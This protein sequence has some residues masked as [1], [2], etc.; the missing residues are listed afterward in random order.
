MFKL[1]VSSIGLTAVLLAASSAQAADTYP[2]AAIEFPPSLYTEGARHAAP[3]D[4]GGARLMFP[5]AA[6]EHAF[7]IEYTDVRSR[8]VQPSVAGSTGSVFPSAAN[9]V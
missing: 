6:V 8:V 2:S 7:S 9:E 1:S 3:V 4:G 5:S